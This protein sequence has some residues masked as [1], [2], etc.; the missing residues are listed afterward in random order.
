MVEWRVPAIQV[1]LEAIA[2]N[3]CCARPATALA[4][5]R[6]IQQVAQ[7]LYA[8]V[9]PDGKAP[10]AASRSCAQVVQDLVQLQLQPSRA[11]ETA[12]AT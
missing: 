2:Q 8:S 1:L 6:A 11:V 7:D 12:F 4:M 5:A 3:H 9:A 10:P